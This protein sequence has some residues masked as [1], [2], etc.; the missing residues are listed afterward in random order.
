M[1]K[2]GIPVQSLELFRLDAAAKYVTE[3]EPRQN[4]KLFCVINVVVFVFDS[5]GRAVSGIRY[6]EFKASRFA[7]M[8]GMWTNVD[9]QTVDELSR[10]G[11]YFLK[12]FPY[13][14]TRP[15]PNDLIPDAL[16]SEIYLI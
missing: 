8:V 12:F 9:L 16:A 2:I 6:R 7:D 1:A 5:S 10:P 13:R 3:F 11:T 15:D 14:S 4:K